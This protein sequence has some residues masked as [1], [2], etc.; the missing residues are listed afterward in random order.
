[1]KG[2][3]FYGT[4]AFI[5]PGALSAS[6]IAVREM[7]IE[8]VSQETGGKFSVE[9]ITNSINEWVRENGKIQPIKM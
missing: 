3:G 1:M 6:N 7:L 4:N 9:Q 2:E 5:C 8:A